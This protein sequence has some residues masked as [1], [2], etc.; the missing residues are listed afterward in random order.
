[1][2]N[3]MK[4]VIS[5][6]QDRKIQKLGYLLM[7]I[8][9]KQISQLKMIQVRI[10]KKYFT[11][12]EIISTRDDDLY[13]QAEMLQVIRILFLVIMPLVMLNLLIF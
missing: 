12:K 7:N 5:Y 3:L 4:L 9:G 2:D 8:L 6:L 13:C 1:M 10:L 11:Q